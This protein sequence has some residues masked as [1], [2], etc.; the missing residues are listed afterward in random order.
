VLVCGMRWNAE[1]CLKSLVFVATGNVV[2][3]V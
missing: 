2:S 1:G 3:E